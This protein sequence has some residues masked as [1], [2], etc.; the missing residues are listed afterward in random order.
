MNDT[1][2]PVDAASVSRRDPAL[3]VAVGA[4]AYI[5]AGASLFMT[6]WAHDDGTDRLANPDL[7][8][9]L[10]YYVYSFPLGLPAWPF[11]RSILVP[12]LTMIPNVIVMGSLL[13]RRLSRL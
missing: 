8:F 6:L 5:V 13:Y 3:Y 9:G 7:W 10:F 4:L 11:T 12:F 1:G 2:S